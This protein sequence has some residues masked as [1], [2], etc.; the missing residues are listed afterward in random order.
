MDKVSIIVPIFNSEKYLRTSIE[1]ILNQSYKNF[2]LILINDGS[3]DGSLDICKEY[4]DKD[5]RIVLI[6]KNNEG[7]SSARNEGIDKSTGKYIVFCDS[8]DYI[9]KNYFKYLYK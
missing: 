2:E 7:V 8:D 3:S 1:S 4:I 5:E 9:E 6:N